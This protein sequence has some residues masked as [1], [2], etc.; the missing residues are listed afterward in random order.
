MLNIGNTGSGEI[1]FIATKFQEKNLY[2]SC[3][4][5]NR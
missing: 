2:S 3:L 5:I 4:Y 1:D